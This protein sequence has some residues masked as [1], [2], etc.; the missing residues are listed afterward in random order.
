[1]ATGP[2]ERD[3]TIKGEGFA[4]FLISFLVPDN[5]SKALAALAPVGI[6]T[7]KVDLVRRG[8]T[9]GTAEDVRHGAGE[10]MIRFL[11]AHLKV[12]TLPQEISRQALVD[13]AIGNLPAVEAIYQVVS[14]ARPE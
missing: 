7:V 1:M 11:A 5:A 10:I 3:A 12:W 6:G 14:T 9:Q 8:C 2:E 4:P 13:L